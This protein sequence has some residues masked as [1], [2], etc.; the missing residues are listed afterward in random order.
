GEQSIAVDTVSGATVS[1]KAF[2][3]C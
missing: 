2:L 1:S 3:N